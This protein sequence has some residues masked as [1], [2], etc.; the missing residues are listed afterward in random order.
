VLGVLFI[1]VVFFVPGGLVRFGRVR[2]LK[3]AFQ[4]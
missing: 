4:R 1:L 3:E 2:R